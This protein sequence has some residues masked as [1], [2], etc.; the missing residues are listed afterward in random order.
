MGKARADS[1]KT[2]RTYF[3]LITSC[4]PKIRKT[5]S[6]DYAQLKKWQAGRIYSTYGNRD[7][8]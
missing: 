5:H 3:N 8:V 6:S 7:F 2:S 4:Y 1:T